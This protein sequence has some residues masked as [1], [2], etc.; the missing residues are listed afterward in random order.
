MPA[1]KN[2]YQQMR[3]FMA[4]VL[5]GDLAIFILYLLAA[6]FGVIW[7][8]A[9][10]AIIAILTSVL[11]LVYLYLT[12]EI[13]KKRSLWMTA[14]AGA[15]LVCLLYSLVLN[16]PCPLPSPEEIKI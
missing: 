8:K 6:G 10:T 13:F 11:C 2:R 1:K 14:A 7:L 3:K 15:I 4:Y 16:F 5:S 9:L 12:Q